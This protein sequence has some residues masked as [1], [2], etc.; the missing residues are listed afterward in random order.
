MTTLTVAPTPT[1]L[2]PAGLTDRQIEQR[3][4]YVTASEIAALFSLHPFKSAYD[5][6]LEKT[7]RLDRDE[8]GAAAQAGNFAEDACLKFAQHRLRIEMSD[9][10][11]KLTRQNQ[12]RVHKNGLM[13]C[14]YDAR[15][16]GSNR[17]LVEA[18]STGLVH[19]NVDFSEWGDEMTDQVPSHIL[20][21]TQAQMACMGPDCREVFIPVWLSWKGFRLYRIERSEE[22]IAKLEAKVREFF[23]QHID[24]GLPPDDAPSLDT[25]K[26]IPKQDR[27]IGVAIEDRYFEAYH[28]A[29]ERAKRAEET[30]ERAKALL[31]GQMGDSKTAHSPAGHKVINVRMKAKDVPARHQEAKEYPRINVSKKALAAD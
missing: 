7:Q 25:L 31:L 24:P 20:I 23:E 6:F 12:F 21:Q 28:R 14:T 27:D 3:R 16:A 4:N 18:K 1:N 19:P 26:R 11:L 22:I 10:K 15:V 17:R 2:D 29:N 9:P 13:S 5:V 8:A 30:A